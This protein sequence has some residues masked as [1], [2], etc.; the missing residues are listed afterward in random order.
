MNRK[1]IW[2]KTFSVPKTA[3]Q[4][5]HS[6]L[7]GSGTMVKY[8]SNGSMVLPVLQ[9][10]VSSTIKHLGLEI[11]VESPLLLV[12]FMNCLEKLVRILPQSTNSFLRKS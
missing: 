12:I 11:P 5:F 7:I 8:F 3:N 1:S 9:S 6:Q 4:R 2:N 10:K